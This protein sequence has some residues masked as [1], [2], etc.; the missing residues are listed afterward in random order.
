MV[1]FLKLSNLH[2]L[3]YSMVEKNTH[4]IKSAA[5]TLG[6]EYCGIARAEKLEE[7]A[8]RLENW[9][10]KGFQGKM[11]YMENYFD[12]RIDPVKLVPGAKSVVTLLLNYFPSQKQ[13]DI[14]A[15]IVSK[16]AYGKDYHEVIKT[17]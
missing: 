2:F 11:S 9:L 16:Y 15:P 7:D 13:S 10:N 12:L 17:K 4:L 6:F 1:S 5:K 14:D 3:F 8:R